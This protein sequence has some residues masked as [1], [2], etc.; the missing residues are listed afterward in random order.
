LKILI[1]GA[2]GLLG[3]EIS[4]KAGQPASSNLRISQIIR[5][6][7]RK[8]PG[9]LTAD[10]TSEEGIRRICGSDWDILVHAA[11]W[12]NPDQCENERDGALRLNAWATE[13]LASE[14]GRRKAKM[15]YVSTDYVFPGSNPPYKEEDTPSPVNYYGETKLLG[16]KAV[17]GQCQ[18]S[19]ILRVPLL[20]GMAAGLQKSDLLNGTLK[21]LS[22][23]KPW[24]MED[25]IVRY[26]TYTGDV[27]DAI[28]FLLDRNA[29]GIF[30]FSGQDRTSRYKITA[31]FADIFGRSMKNIV[32]LERAPAT[33]ARRPH[34]SHLG[35]DK[36][37]SMGFPLPMPFAE[38]IKFLKPQIT[39]E[40]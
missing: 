24:N 37:L 13:Q 1:T 30:H 28:F 39:R 26:P 5:L 22:S 38:R 23:D 32:R 33:E 19:L 34:D 14:A 7:S 11:A 31:T 4:A 29:S 27:A 17:L 9:F 20:Y 25:S 8:V 21:A 10:I 12:R 3:S 15:L 2:G 40:L 16:E 18:N 6:S 36:I 35:M